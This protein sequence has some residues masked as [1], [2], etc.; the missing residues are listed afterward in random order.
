MQPGELA[1]LGLPP[2]GETTINIEESARMDVNDYFGKRAK[3]VDPNKIVQKTQ[4]LV[5]SWLNEWKEIFNQIG[6]L[7][8][9]Y[10]SDEDVM[11]IAE[12]QGLDFKCSANDIRGQWDMSIEFD[13]RD[14]DMEFLQQKLD[15]IMQVA[16]PADAGG[17]IDRNQLTRVIMNVIDPNLAQML[18]R[19]D[20]H[21]SQAEV[22]D[23]RSNL[24]SIL[25]CVAPPMVEKGQ[26]YQLRLQTLQQAVQSSP[27]ISMILQGNPEVQ[28]LYTERVK[29][30]QFQIQQQQNA[31]V[32]KLGVQP[33]Q[34]QPVA[35]TPAQAGGKDNE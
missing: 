35:S 20:A 4:R 23:E 6:Q 16:I 31:T 17:V 29:F 25:N 7:C 8:Q 34:G 19:D 26:N 9:Q 3:D 1:W 32:G 15:L 5:D 24:V 21:A 12:A 14:L 2:M 33:Q 28:K 10:L 27:Q 22:Q 18:V 13:A 11:K 30:L